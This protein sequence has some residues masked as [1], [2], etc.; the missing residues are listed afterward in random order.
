MLSLFGACVFTLLQQFHVCTVAGDKELAMAMA[1]A[2]KRLLPRC[3]A[4][5]QQTM[6]HIAKHKYELPSVRC[7]ARCRL[8]IR[9]AG[10]GPMEQDGMTGPV[11]SSA[12]TIIHAAAANRRIPG[13]S[14]TSSADVLTSLSTSWRV[15]EAYLLR[16]LPQDD[17]HRPIPPASFRCHQNS[18]SY[19]GRTCWAG[20][21][22]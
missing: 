12:E 16:T 6:R 1:A 8:L 4:R 19:R 3:S 2:S 15:C 22:L 10:T 11:A 21:A 18:S 7:E 13:A 17:I 9:C 20:C 5:L 14:I